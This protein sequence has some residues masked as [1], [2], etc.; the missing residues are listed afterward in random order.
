MR[1]SGCVQLAKKR[2]SALV[3]IAEAR[4]NRL[5]LDSNTSSSA[6]KQVLDLNTGPE[7]RVSNTLAVELL[8][9]H[10]RHN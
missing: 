10:S 1:N 2:H 4:T 3:L 9:S 7:G 6:R 5:T 8:D